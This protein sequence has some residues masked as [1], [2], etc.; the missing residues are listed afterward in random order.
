M[1]DFNQNIV[2]FVEDEDDVVKCVKFVEKHYL[3]VA[4]AAGRHSYHGAS[5]CTGMIIGISREI[6]QLIK[7]GYANMSARSGE[8]EEGL[9]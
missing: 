7:L 4:V 6:L 2:V 1:L 8:D 9:P 3:D 5:S